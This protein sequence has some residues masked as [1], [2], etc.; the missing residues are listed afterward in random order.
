MKFI[1]NY[2][3]T[4]INLPP[5]SLFI[6]LFQAVA[7][8]LIAAIPLMGSGKTDFVQSGNSYPFNS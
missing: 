2:N 1:Y 6:F 7:A 4:V 5:R 3:N 8:L